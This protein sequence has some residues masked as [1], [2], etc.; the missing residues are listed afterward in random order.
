MSNKSFRTHCCSLLGL[1]LTLSLPLP[2]A[3]PD[4]VKMREE[5]LALPT[6]LAGEPD[7]SPIFYTGRVYQGA[8]GAIYPY[9]L[10]DK[11]TEVRENK[12]YQAVYLE[13]RYLQISVLPEIGGR[14][15]SGLD[16]T[17]QYDFFYRQHVIK[18]ALVGML[19]AWVSGG[20]EWNIPHHHRASSF[21]P[22]DYTL[23][24]NPDGSKTVWVGETEWRHRLKWV[25]GVTLFPGKSYL[26]VTV[27]LFNRT[28]LA[29]S[30]LYWANPAVH[31]NRDYQVIFPPSTKLATFHG[32]TQ[33]SRWPISKSVFNAVDYSP[34]VDISW[35]KNHPSPTSF[36]AWQVN[37]DFHAGYDHGR[38]AGVVHVADHETVPGKKFWEWGNGPEGRLW[39]RLLTET[40]GPY[41]EL[42]VGAFS[43]NQPDYSWCQPYEVKVFK[44]YWYPIRDIGGIKNGNREAAVNLEVDPQG[45]AT[46]GF[47]TTSEHRNATARLQEGTRILLEQTFD[48][49]PARPF[50][51]TWKLPA[52][53]QPAALKATLLA[54]GQE[55][56]AYSPVQVKEPEMPL[57]ASPPKPPQEV[58]S[59]EEL[60]LTGLR[61][62]QL[63]SPAYPPELFYEEALRRDPGDSRAN[64]ALGLLLC[65]KG[66]FAE[67]EKNLRAAVQ[68]VTANYVRP[69]EAEAFYYLGVALRAQGQT[70]AARDAF[71][72][73]TWD[74]E[75]RG[76]S[77]FALAEMTAAERS[78]P[79]A[80][81]LVNHA[82]S[83]NAWNTQ[84]LNL[85]TAILRHL[86]RHS[87]AQEL[88]SATLR[89]D[90]LDFRAGNELP[91][92]HAALGQ[93]AEA[94]AARKALAQRMR[95]EPQSYL[96]LAVDYENAGMWEEAIAVLTRKLD[97]GEGRQ[98]P[99]LA[100]HLGF[101]WQQKGDPVRALDF[102]RRGGRMSPDYCFPFRAESISVLQQAKLA[103]AQDPRASYFL[104]NL[105]YD[106]QPAEALRQWEL[107]R[108]LDL[109]FAPV[110]RNLGFAYAHL[111]NNLPKAVA[112]LEQ[113]VALDPE[114]ARYWYELDVVLEASGAPPERR[115][116]LLEKHLQTIVKR[117]DALARLVKLY[118]LLGD[119]DKALY[120]L[121]HHHFHVWEGIEGMHADFVA[122]HLLRGQK[123]AAEGQH[124]QA[125]RDYQ[126]ALE[127][128]E[129]LEVAPRYGRQEFPHIYYWIGTAHEALGDTQKARESYQ[130][131][132]EGRA[133]GSE[134]DYFRALALRKLARNL[135]ANQIGSS[136]VQTGGKRLSTTPL[137]NPFSRF[138]TARS[139]RAWKASAHYL[140]GLGLLAQNKTKE[141]APELQEVLSLDAN[142]LGAIVEL[143][144]LRQR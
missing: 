98:D 7:K 22:V 27:K 92:I 49:D 5:P 132:A 15:F 9:A 70:A 93:Q 17:N 144:N 54:E 11:L 72:R 57:P 61:L 87:E 39:D 31:A 140:I 4:S 113:A 85:K 99:L 81:E 32:K 75:W 33:F 138:E 102:F 37:E 97:S 107:A 40:D 116:T 118:V 86:N 94:E 108:A 34:G 103:N 21:L 25:V 124:A 90:P 71:Y 53:T 26:E 73:A 69:K 78:F 74:A 106:S 6:Y 128:P 35:W 84:A 45:L 51:K 10:M 58:P 77:Y 112:S 13:N 46:L 141:A 111:E 2:A 137:I 1:M 131:A 114:E 65:R 143:K 126:A 48:I 119:H 122:A 50:V 123:F 56:I 120:W 142:H 44:Q 109:S 12:S 64:A 110:H 47:Y 43:D 89:L 125:L 29:H 117:D 30:V 121:E 60:Y 134:T 115:R 52:G 19:G 130:K 88:A 129:N 82:L 66:R 104:G 101:A 67:A 139:E 36:F 3:P 23:S 59:L 16:K 62:E 105:L 63:Y 24:Q 136:L 76:A 14:I 127:F 18:P 91:M 68:R 80:L 41:I 42:M 28:P 133:E 79:K 20:V 95:G 38:K 100:Y 83:V 55:L 96:E 135:E 8:K